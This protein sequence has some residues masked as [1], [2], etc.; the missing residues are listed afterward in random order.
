MAELREA[1]EGDDEYQRNGPRAIVEFPSGSSW[2]AITDLAIHGAV[3]GQHSLDQT[4]FLPVDA[5]RDPA[6]ASIRILERLTG[7]ALE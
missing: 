5:M 1:G 3:S 2:L 6:R 4:F 7:K